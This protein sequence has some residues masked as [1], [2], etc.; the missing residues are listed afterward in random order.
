MSCLNDL[1]ICYRNFNV[2]HEFSLTELG[3]T[4]LKMGPWVITQHSDNGYPLL[5]NS[6]AVLFKL[7]SLFIFP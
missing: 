6:Q 4:Y 5:M 7:F 1:M 2:N 3:K